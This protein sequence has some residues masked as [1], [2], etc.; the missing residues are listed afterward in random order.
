MKKVRVRRLGIGLGWSLHE[1]G[2]ISILISQVTQ[3]CPIV[4]KEVEVIDEDGF[5]IRN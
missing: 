2:I 4:E 3:N 5:E 1:T